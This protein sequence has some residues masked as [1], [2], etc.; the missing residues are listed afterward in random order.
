MRFIINFY[1]CGG[2]KRGSGGKQRKAAAFPEF[3]EHR[4]H[5]KPQTMQNIKCVVVG[6]GAV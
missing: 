1:S 6:D 3:D 2:K 5:H 4:I